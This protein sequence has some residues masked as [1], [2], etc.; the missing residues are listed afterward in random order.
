VANGLVAPGGLMV[1]NIKNHIRK[2][3]DDSIEMH[4]AE[5]YLGV[6]TRLGLRLLSAAPV[7]VPDMRNGA[8]SALRAD[9]E[10]LLVFRKPDEVQEA[11]V[12]AGQLAGEQLR[13]I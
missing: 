9:A 1:I 8:N 12:A 2:V 7:Q 5:W 6:L 4:V 11:L 13:L 10:F 3:G